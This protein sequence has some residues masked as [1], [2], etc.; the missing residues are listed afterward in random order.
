MTFGK[1]SSLNHSDFWK[2][3]FFEPEASLIC[4]NFQR[5]R[6][7]IWYPLYKLYKW[8]C[9]QNRDRL[10]KRNYGCQREE[11]VWEFGMVIYTLLF[12]KWIT[13]WDLLYST[14][15]S[16]QCYVAAW[17]WGVLGENGCMYVYGWV[18]SLF[19]WDYHNIVNQVYS[20][21]K[22]KVQKKKNTKV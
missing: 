4:L 12:L 16:A 6:N 17:I 5:R 2:V 9:L 22:E 15:N 8:T 10:T 21:T 18:P 19:T 11:I 7:T 14:W 13:S 20:D 1:S 3:K